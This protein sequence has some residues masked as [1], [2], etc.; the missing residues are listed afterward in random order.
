MIQVSRKFFQLAFYLVASCP[1]LGGAAETL[2]HPQGLDAQLRQVEVPYLAEQVRLRGDAERGALLFYKSAAACVQCHSSDQNRSPL[3]PSLSALPADTSLE[4]LVNAVLRPSE[5]IAKGFETNVVVTSDGNVLSGL[6]VRENDDELVL[7]D[8]KDLQKEIRIDQDDIEDHQLATQSMMPEGLAGTLADQSEFL[9]LVAYVAAIAAGG[10][11]AEARL[12]PSAEALLVKDDSQN[13]DHAGIVKGLRSRDFNEG[14]LIYHGYCAECHGADGNTPSLPTARAFGTQKLK[15]GADPYRM[16]MTLTRGNGLMAPM[17]HLT[18]KER[19]QVVHYIREAFMRPSNSEYEKVTTEYLAGL[20]KGTELGTE[21]PYVERD[22]GPALASQLRR[23]FSSVLSIRLG[24]QT[25]AYDTHTM[26]QAD[27]WSGGFVEIG[28]TQHAR[29]RGEGTVN[30]AGTSVQGLAG[31]KWGHD[32]TFDY[33]RKGLLPRGPLPKEWLRYHGHSLFGDQVVLRYEI[34]GRLIWELPTAEPAIADFPQTIGI[35]HAMR[36]EPGKALT[37]AVAQV[38]EAND[39]LLESAAGSLGVVLGKRQ[40]GNW[41]SW[42]AATVLGQVEGMGWSIDEQNRIVLQI[43]ASPEARVIEICRSSGQGA[44]ALEAVQQQLS[45]YASTAQIVDPQSCSEG[46]PLLWP[47]VLHTTGTLGLEKG[48]YALDTIAIPRQTPWNTWFRTSA[49]DFFDDGRMAI[50]TYGGDV[51][52]VS[53]VDEQLLDLK[54]KR[55]AGGMY[56]PMGLKVV[57][58]Q[59]YVTCKDR[60]TRLHDVDDNGEAD[61]YESF[62]ADDDVSVNF[63]AFNFDLQVD[64]D[65]NFYYAKAGHGADYAIP[66]A[67]IKISPDGEHREIYCTGFRSPNGMGILPDNRLTVSDNQGQWTPASKINLVKKGGFYGWVP[68]Y[69]IPGKW[70]PDGGAIDLDKLVPPTTFDRPLVYM[71]QEF[72]NSSGGQVWVDDPRWGPLSGRLL[73]TSFGKGWMSYVLMQEVEGESQAAIIKLP[74]DF[75]TGIMRAEVNPVDGQVYAVGLQGWNGGGRPRMADKGIQRLR[76]TGNEEWMVTGAVVEPDGLRFRFTTPVDAKTAS[77]PAS[78]AIKHWDYLWQAS[79]GSKMYSPTTG[80]VGPDTL[81]VSKVEMDADNKGVK[82]IIPGLQPVD[83][84][85]LI[86]NLQ[87]PAG[88]ALLEEVYWTI[89]RMPK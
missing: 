37:L 64:T 1:L 82:L 73:H 46:G 43:P 7:R 45:T 27:F 23:D 76:A 83:Q 29:G 85:H 50:A 17:G 21:V 77:D 52:I 86:M 33:S 49:V 51:W 71:P 32:G 70:A 54:W 19:Y 57:D 25:I 44:K 74:F 16:F 28:Q 31:W 35:R 13:L 67:I 62:S 22:F 65:K 55:F 34:D 30:P 26:D 47:E 5:K 48:A 20:P 40:E 36:V 41:Q 53:G 58:G 8:A 39:Q 4:Y 11:E 24:D 42:T 89:N 84:L 59:V 78:Y 80:E 10:A 72:D 18:P 66:G 14:S 38:P 79:Y 9:D 87:D 12:K 56:E 15:F 3:G 88:K 75:E 6:V 68:T 60:I 63:H 69:S 61:F 81:T 2:R